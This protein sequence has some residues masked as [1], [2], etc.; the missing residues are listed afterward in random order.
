[1]KEDKKFVPGVEKEKD[2]RTS[3]SRKDSKG[4]FQKDGKRSGR[5]RNKR[6][7]SP[8]DTSMDPRSPRTPEGTSSRFDNALE[9]YSKY[10]RLL[11][12]TATLPFPNR[13]GMSLDLGIS[14]NV[15][16]SSIIPGVVALDYFPTCGFS[17]KVSDPISLVA[18]ELYAR[19]RANYS[20]DLEADGP[21]MVVYIMALGSI[22]AYIT[23][24][25]RIY[26]LLDAYEPEN[27]IT[28]NH[29]LH[30]IGLVDDDIIDLRSHKT[31]LY[32]YINEMVHQFNTFL[33]PD[34]FDIINR[35][36]WMNDYIF[37]DAPSTV[38]NCQ[39]YLY[40][41]IGFYE[42]SLLPVSGAGGAE[43][44]G[45][46][47]T[48]APWVA[49]KLT[50]QATDAA[51]ALFNF[52]SGLLNSLYTWSTA[53]TINGYFAKVFGTEKLFTLGE[54]AIDERQDY[55]YTEE[56][57]SQIENFRCG[58]TPRLSTD[59][60]SVLDDW[61]LGGLNISQNVTTN[62]IV[63]NN[64]MT[65]PV[66]VMANSANVMNNWVKIWSD[67][68]PFI[69]VHSDIP[70]AADV[71]IASRMSPVILE[72]HKVGG[73]SV[74]SGVNTFTTQMDTGTEYPFGIRLIQGRDEDGE[75]PL[76]FNVLPGLNVDSLIYN[77]SI[78]SQ[79]LYL[80]QFDWHPMLTFASAH[81]THNNHAYVYGDTWNI[82]STTPEAMRKIHRV[83]L[84]SEFNAFS[85]I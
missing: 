67:M 11:A 4:K 22:A 33:I 69:N 44:S 13:P 78:P 60:A 71:V 52:G 68:R 51:V 83:C 16:Q 14:D 7:P 66:Y 5:N 15:T 18:R 82:T 28:P 63:C 19:V 50:T 84:F 40:N 32:G 9:W 56:V 24:C 12:A 80:S 27:Y 72:V 74:T 20:A 8:E 29:V 81:N 2:P 46:R 48:F 85:L 45:C 61:K 38:L 64:Q 54:L 10:P 30:A 62:S 42:Y 79:W 34:V 43:A 41:Q 39:L 55:N 26:R 49:G 58:P 73:A 65:Y 53:R 70:G 37:S 35:H 47:M 31:D 36:V 23:A 75:P 25:K 17:E 59:S 6:P 21:D 57:L 1:M 76:S 77:A 3:K